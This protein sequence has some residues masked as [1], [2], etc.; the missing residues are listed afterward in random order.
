MDMGWPSCGPGW[1]SCGLGCL[2]C[3]L[4]TPLGVEY[5]GDEG[6]FIRAPHAEQKLAPAATSLA[7]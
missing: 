2:S 5:D 3:V 4:E 6:W 1:L 7:H